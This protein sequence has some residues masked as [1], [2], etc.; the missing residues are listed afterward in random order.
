MG[1][2][3]G[4]QRKLW[5]LITHTTVKTRGCYHSAD[6][7][8]QDQEVRCQRQQAHFT[9]QLCIR[10]ALVVPHKPGHTRPHVAI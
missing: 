10:L 7:F 4:T 8:V 5:F 1:G 9:T 2:G 6:I 3:G